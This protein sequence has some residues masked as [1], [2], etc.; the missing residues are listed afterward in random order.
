MHNHESENEMQPNEGLHSRRRLLQGVAGVAVG[1]AGVAGVTLL[2]SIGAFAAGDKGKKPTAVQDILNIA[3]TAERLAVTFYSQGIANAHKLG[4]SGDRLNYLRAA[5]V[6]EQIHEFYLRDNKAKPL[7]S[8]FSFPHGADTFKK[9]SLFIATQQELEGFFDSAYLAAVREFAEQNQPRL[10]QIAAQIATIE[11]EHRVLG[12]VL[13]GESFADNWAYTPVAITRVSD[14]PAAVAKAGY[15]SPK[16]DNSYTFA[17]VNI[18]LPAVI[19][20]TPLVGTV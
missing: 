18:D 15:L 9:L 17:A 13:L 5:V 3:R 1:A 8:T 4:I 10:A 20:R 6:E 11:S 12:R 7:T 19:N 14:A 16:G 2:P